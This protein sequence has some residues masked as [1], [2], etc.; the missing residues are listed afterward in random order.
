M[1]QDEL[2]KLMH[3]YD[4]KVFVRKCELVIWEKQISSLGIHFPVVKISKP[5]QCVF[6]T[7]HYNIYPRNVDS[8]FD[9]DYFQIIK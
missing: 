8:T 7:L 2:Q 5:H 3:F 6:L 9:G 1:W 4:L